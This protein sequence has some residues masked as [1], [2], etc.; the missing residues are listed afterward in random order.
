MCSSDLLAVLGLG[1]CCLG[2]PNGEQIREHLGIPETCRVL[3]LQ[4]VGYPAESWE[5]GG[6][7]PRQPFES[8]FSMNT[9]AT[10]FPRSDEVVDELTADGLFTTPAPLP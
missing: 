4:T 10:P 8:L 5:A 6:Q 3:M 2:T 9:Y 1:T 7:R